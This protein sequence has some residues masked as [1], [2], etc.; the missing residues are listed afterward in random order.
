MQTIQMKPSWAR[1][2]TRS[3]SR[4]PSHRRE[5]S[6]FRVYATYVGRADGRDGPTSD[7]RVFDSA[8]LEIDDTRRDS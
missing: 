6:F 8:A 5:T 2:A 4:L 1:G 3:N 7:N